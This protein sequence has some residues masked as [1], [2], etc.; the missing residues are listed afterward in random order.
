MSTRN[1]APEPNHLQSL[2]SPQARSTLGR[3]SRVIESVRVARPCRLTVSE[4]CPTAGPFAYFSEIQAAR[5]IITFGRSANEG[6]NDTAP[7]VSQFCCSLVPLIQQRRKPRFN[8]GQPTTW[9]ALPNSSANGRRTRIEHGHLPCSLPSR[10]SP[11]FP[12]RLAA[13]RGREVRCSRPK[14]ERGRG[15]GAARVS[16]HLLHA[17]A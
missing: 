4:P 2:S 12:N 11:V 17:H 10:K 15:G 6:G 3:A 9:D 1:V 13:L 5:L 16:T 8:G 7:G 14:C